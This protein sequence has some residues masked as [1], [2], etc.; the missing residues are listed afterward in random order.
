MFIDDDGGDDDFAE[1][2]Y[3]YTNTPSITLT[4]YA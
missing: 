2:T 1:K 3:T 4:M